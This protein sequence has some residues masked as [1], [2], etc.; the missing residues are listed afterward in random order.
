MHQIS[1]ERR[2]PDCNITESG[3]GH[4]NAVLL[5]NNFRD[6]GLVAYDLPIS[7]LNHRAFIEW[8]TGLFRNIVASIW[9]K[10]ST[11]AIERES[12]NPRFMRI[13]A[14]MPD[15]LGMN[16]FF[17]ILVKNATLSGGVITEYKERDDL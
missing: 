4:G 13:R 3:Y 14:I 16:D 8:R 15:T 5:Q 2:N 6:R 10:A 7:D 1:A 17:D 9:A 11:L 12:Q